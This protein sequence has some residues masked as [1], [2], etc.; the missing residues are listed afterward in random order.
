MGDDETQASVDEALETMGAPD[1]TP[2]AHEA[3]GSISSQAGSDAI[4]ITTNRADGSQTREEIRMDSMNYGSRTDYADG[5]TD[6]AHVYGGTMES[7]HTETDA[8]GRQREHLEYQDPDGS[9][10]TVDETHPG[11]DASGLD[12]L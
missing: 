8:D 1:Y 12:D 4:E 6:S 3:G 9:T 5:S 2:P 7:G 10:R 11:P